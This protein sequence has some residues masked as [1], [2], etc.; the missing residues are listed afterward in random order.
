MG[1]LEMKNGGRGLG[2]G[3][4]EF[5]ERGVEGKG[6]ADTEKFNA[7]AAKGV[8]I[9]GNQFPVMFFA[10]EAKNDH[11]GERESA[12]NALRL[13]GS[14]DLGKD[15]VEILGELP[16]GIV[17]LEFAQ[18]GNVANVIALARFFDIF[19]VQLFAGHG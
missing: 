10:A 6:V 5:V 4:K 16:I 18:V 17:R 12:R 13:L 19:P 1:G 7:A 15:G 9:S 14:D 11:A 2:E 3:S 8:G